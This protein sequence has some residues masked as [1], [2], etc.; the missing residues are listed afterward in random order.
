MKKFTLLLL[1]LLFLLSCATSPPKVITITKI[2]PVPCPEPN[3]PQRPALPKAEFTSPVDT[4]AVVALKDLDTKELI[5]IILSLKE[6]ALSLEE[7]LKG[8]KEDALKRNEAIRR[9]D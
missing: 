3:I 2:V 1:V 8:Y 9:N 7:L 6:Y 5:G 4:E